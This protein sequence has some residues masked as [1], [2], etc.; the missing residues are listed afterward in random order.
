M[1]RDEVLTALRD[2]HAAVQPPV[3]NDRG[4]PDR[5]DRTGCLCTL[6]PQVVA[7]L[8]DELDPP[9][10]ADGLA[11]ITAERRRQV[12]VEGWSPSHDDEHTDGAMAAAA[13][14][15]A[16]FASLSDVRRNSAGTRERMLD[17]WPWEPEWWK[18]SDRVRDL[19]KAGALIAAE[20]DRL[21][22]K[23]RAEVPRG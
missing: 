7:W 13:A 5:R 21:Q 23:A 16:T 15:Y 4:A 10:A 14:C 17:D 22:R 20:I 1:S 11:L 12:D 9:A 8:I 6:S 3:K 18:P 2:A 19:V